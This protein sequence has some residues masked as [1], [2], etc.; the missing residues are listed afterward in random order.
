MKPYLYVDET[1]QDTSGGLFIVGIVV[2][3][4]DR[5]DDLAD[6]LT[7]IEQRTLKGQ[8]KWMRSSKSPRLAYMRAVLRELAPMFQMF[9][10]IHHNTR[11]YISATASTT[12]DVLLLIAGSEDRAMV[13]VDALSRE[14]RREIG[15]LLRRRTARADVRGVSKDENSSLIRLAD[16]IAGFVRDALEGGAEE[17][18]LWRWALREG[19]LRDVVDE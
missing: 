7:E 1:G 15:V 11:D 12:A 8:R 4:L 6:R 5:R 16:A 9:Y 3:S 18:H 10:G 17:S 19:R 14:G 2:V 13:L